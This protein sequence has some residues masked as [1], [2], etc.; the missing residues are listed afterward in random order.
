M[1]KLVT[2]E[3]SDDR[4]N[5]ISLAIDSISYRFGAAGRERK[6]HIKESY[7]HIFNL[8]V[9]S[10]HRYLLW[11]AH[12]H[13]HLFAPNMTAPH[14]TNIQA[15]GNE[16]AGYE[17]SRKITENSLQVGSAL[18]L[19]NLEDNEKWYGEM[20]EMLGDLSS[21]ADRILFHQNQLQER[22][23]RLINLILRLCETKNSNERQASDLDNLFLDVR[24]ILTPIQCANFI[25]FIEKY[26]YRH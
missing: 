19:T 20:K 1:E 9:P 18:D 21:K 15:G 24:D 25:L 23:E 17:Q 16:S 11:A 2:E 26:A 12:N 10:I 5:E 3:E 6:E 8:A 7:K 22:R 4:N 13:T 14:E